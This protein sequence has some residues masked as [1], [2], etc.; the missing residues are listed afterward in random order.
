MNWMNITKDE[1]A[2]L[3]YEDKSQESPTEVLAKRRR[4]NSHEIN[5]DRK[6][7]ITFQ[8]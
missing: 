4:E 3:K 7:K 2:V 5:N 8:N 1:G 6:G